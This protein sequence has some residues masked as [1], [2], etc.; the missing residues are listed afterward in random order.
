MKKQ[1]VKA[2][3]F[4]ALLAVI[5]GVLSP[6]F[7][8]AN[9]LGGISGEPDNSLDYLAI[10][11]SECYT[12]VSPLDMWKDR[13]YAGY[14]CGVA[15]QRPQDAYY[16]LK[17]TLARQ[18][19]KVVLLETNMFYRRYG[20]NKETQT[21][22]DHCAADIV[23]L[24]KY[25]DRWKTVT[26]LRNVRVV[27]K[28]KV[29]MYKGM[30]YMTEAAAYT[31][32]SY[33]AKTDDVQNMRFM[34][35]MYL[36]KIT[37]LCKDRNIQLVLYSTP[38]PANWQEGKHNAVEAYAKA[39]GLTFLDLNLVTG[40]IGINWTTDTYDRGDHLNFSGTQ[41]VSAYLEKYLSEHAPL[42]D[43]RGDARYAA[44]NDELSVYLKE[45]GQTQS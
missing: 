27:K 38:S 9:A 7:T 6:V 5:I 22:F 43:H 34:Q 17:K 3:A 14:N 8:P 41:K 35:R 21:I 18:S 44:W 16:R 25:H 11:D 36:D 12:S 23:A 33:V 30:Q 10:G 2:V 28:S 32:G 45:T 24:Y 19:P 29:K 39:H 31:R 40:D 13:G 26:P 4:I 20:F 15:A 42:P 1:A 37:K